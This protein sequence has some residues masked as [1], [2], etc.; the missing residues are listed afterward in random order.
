MTT[1]DP[2]SVNWSSSDIAIEDITIG[3][4]REITDSDSTGLW[5]FSDNLF[6][7]VDASNDTACVPITENLDVF[8][9]VSNEFFSDESGLFEEVD[10]EI[11]VRLPETDFTAAD[12][13]GTWHLFRQ[14]DVTFESNESDDSGYA[15]IFHARDELV[16]NSNGTF[17]LTEIETTDPSG[18]DS[19]FSGTWNTAN[20]QI[21]LMVGND[22]LNIAN[23]SSGLDTFINHRL[24]TFN[25]ATFTN[26]DRSIEVAIKEPSTLS[27]T[28]VLGLWALTEFTTDVDTSG[29]ATNFLFSDAYYGMGY[30]TFKADG[31]GTLEI[32]ETS[33]ASEF[34]SGSFLWVVVGNKIRI[35]DSEL[36]SIE[37][38][39][40][41]E[42]D[43]G[44][45]LYIQ[46]ES[47]GDNELY[48]FATLCKLP[49][50]PGFSASQSNIILGASPD[51]SV[52]TESGLF[53]Q[54]Q[55]SVNLE[56]WS[57]VGEPIA[58]DGTVQNAQ[59][60]SAP[61]DRAFYRWTIVVPAQD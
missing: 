9:F 28:D 21:N 48:N 4:N 29:G 45:S 31:T 13:A 37:F 54:L 47:G 30:V 41:A 46:N 15:V 27:S 18:V 56:A 44:V 17:T 16:L 7:A 33:N 57:D 12:V 25:N 50:A 34:I 60:L 55:R 8:S 10:F 32:F 42:K 2:F 39:V 22:S 24:E 35:I 11:G 5:F 61:N 49:D 59:D 53:Y 38:F 6:N 14:T 20:R 19:P 52:E 26:F 58:G 23:I 43:F 3:S 36:D 40:S 51:I 1:T